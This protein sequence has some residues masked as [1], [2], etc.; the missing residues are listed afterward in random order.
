MPD[1]LKHVLAVIAHGMLT[2]LPAQLVTAAVVAASAALF[3]RVGRRR[4]RTHAEQN[5]EDD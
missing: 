2:E 5:P 1:Q 4:A 3:R